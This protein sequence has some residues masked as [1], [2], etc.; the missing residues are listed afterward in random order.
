[1]TRCVIRYRRN[2]DLARQF[3][4]PSLPY[5]SREEAEALL[6]VCANTNRYEIEDIDDD[7]P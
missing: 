1:M 2:T 3:P 6:R 7:R 4:G 5:A